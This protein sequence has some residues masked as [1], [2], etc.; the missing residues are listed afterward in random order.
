MILTKLLKPTLLGCL[1]FT[2]ATGEVG[3]QHG[4]RFYANLELG[5]NFAPSIRTA[6][7]ANGRGS[8]CD[9]HLNPFTDLMPASCG[10]PN[11]PGTAWSNGFRRGQRV[12]GR[13]SGGI[14]LS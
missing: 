11:A 8:I 4:K 14:P 5:V 9:E 1:L 12:H 10:D 13:W 2:L 3:A 7:D 6:A